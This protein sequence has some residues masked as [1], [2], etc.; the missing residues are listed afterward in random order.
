MVV[1][2]TNYAQLA[3]TKQRLNIPNVNIDSDEKIG[4]HL[5]DADSFVNVQIGVHA[6]VPLTNP[7]PQ[8]ISLASG[9]A[10]SLYNYW[11][12]PAKDRTL[13]G[14]AAWEKRIGDHLKAVYGQKD[15]SGTSGRTFTSSSGVTG[16]E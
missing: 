7:D 9:L 4:A 13:D 1:T 6:V 2:T 12:T 15:I 8:L 10:A 3:E 11:Q 16:A 5:R 14:I